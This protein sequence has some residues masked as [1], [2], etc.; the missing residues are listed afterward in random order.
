MNPRLHSSP[1]VLLWQLS[2]PILSSDWEVSTTIFT[3]L[4]CAVLT[5]ILCY[6]DVEFLSF[7]P[8]N[9]PPSESTLLIQIDT[10]GISKADFA[11]LIAFCSSCKT[12]MT[13]RSVVSHKRCG[14]RAHPAHEESPTKTLLRLLVTS[15]DHTG[16]ISEAQFCALF[17]RCPH[18]FL[19]M[20]WD[21]ARFHDCIFDAVENW[22]ASDLEE[23]S[24]SQFGS[25]RDSSPIQ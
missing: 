23:E 11:E 1:R 10:K 25:G 22:G 7:R 18:C 21:A 2:V 12:Y 13:R 6:P 9:L 5:I 17:S 19:F 4:F 3:A 20:T 15:G 16:G 24:H 8:G 14:Y